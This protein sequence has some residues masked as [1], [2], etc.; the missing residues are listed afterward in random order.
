[1]KNKLKVNLKYLGAILSAM[2]LSACGNAGATPEIPQI[3]SE[4]PVRGVVAEAPIVEVPPAT[5]INLPDFINDGNPAEVGDRIQFGDY[6][7]RVV[8]VSGDENQQSATLL[9][10]YVVHMMPFDGA[11]WEGSAVREWLN[12]DFYFH[13]TPEE[14]SHIVE[15]RASQGANTWFGVVSRTDPS[16][17]RFVDRATVYDKVTIPNLGEAITFLNPSSGDLSILHNR[18]IANVQQQQ[19]G[20]SNRSIPTSPA[21][22]AFINATENSDI[23]RLILELDSENNQSQPVRG[24][25][26]IIG[27]HGFTSVNPR[28]YIAFM[29]DSSG[30]RR[31]VTWWTRSV[32]EET[33][34]SFNHPNRSF[35]NSSGPWS[36]YATFISSHG[37]ISVGGTDPSNTA[38]VRPMLTISSEG[39]EVTSDPIERAVQLIDIPPTEVG[40]GQLPSS[41]A[42][43]TMNFNG[44]A[45]Y[46]AAITPS[47]NTIID[48]T[49]E[50]HSIPANHDNIMLQYTNHVTYHFRNNAVRFEATLRSSS[51]PTHDTRL[52]THIPNL[53]TIYRIFG[54]GELLFTSPELVSVTLDSDYPN[55]YD[56]VLDLP[57]V[58]ELKIE[59]EVTG[60]RPLRHN[61]PRASNLR[62]QN[63]EIGIMNAIVYFR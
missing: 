41:N 28:P 2:L 45:G 1:M 8:H 44:F 6:I 9:S 46:N 42:L 51:Y 50:S 54:D 48:L 55:R 17:R 4:I 52:E 20:G 5:S 53:R 59:M 3:A 37:S 39:A 26:R 23:E 18:P 36:F 43:N 15:T 40:I 14:R 58:N 62:S 32:G 29:R 56:L 27:T 30:M 57:S 11:D 10:E 7:W 19:G 16:Q 60:T 63:R 35:Y 61:F 12:H 31:A 47:G 34:V 22:Q 25:E 21:A 33:S 38:G 24:E 13:F 49:R